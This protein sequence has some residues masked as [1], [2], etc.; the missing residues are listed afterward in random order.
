ME[1]ICWLL[2]A[3]SSILGI[4]F[5]TR[6]WGAACSPVVRPSVMVGIVFNTH[7]GGFTPLDY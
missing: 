3:T 1:S 4:V 6:L 7:E 5:N 2:G